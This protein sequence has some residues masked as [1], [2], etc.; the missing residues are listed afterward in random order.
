M[1]PFIGKGGYH[2]EAM[3][4]VTVGRAR[5]RGLGLKKKDKY[6]GAGVMLVS[7]MRTKPCAKSSKASN[8]RGEGCRAAC[9]VN[10]EMTY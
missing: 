3:R 9:F 8:L 1:A 4:Y 10:G 6:N 5:W 7:L 2:I